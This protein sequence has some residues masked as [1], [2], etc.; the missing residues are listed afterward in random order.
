[1]RLAQAAS[2]GCLPAAEHGP[3]FYSSSL[4]SG[5]AEKAA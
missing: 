1:M 4:Q 2:A 3:P 5:A